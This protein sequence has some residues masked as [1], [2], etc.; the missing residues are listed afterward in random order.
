MFSGFTLEDIFFLFALVRFCEQGKWTGNSAHKRLAVNPEVL[1]NVCAHS[2]P[3][4]Q[5][6]CVCVCVCVSVFQGKQGRAG[7]PPGDF[8]QHL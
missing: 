7:K 6:V 5:G 3:S 2:S 1:C 4:Q 8:T